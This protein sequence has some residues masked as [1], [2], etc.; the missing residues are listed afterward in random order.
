[1]L[2]ALP[3]FPNQSS[4]CLSARQRQREG[5]LDEVEGPNG[6]PLAVVPSFALLAANLLEWGEADRLDAEALL[7]ATGLE[8]LPEVFL[9]GPW[10]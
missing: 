8:R 4:A 7:A 1:V 5:L 3:L 2:N 10:G 9:D 6:Q